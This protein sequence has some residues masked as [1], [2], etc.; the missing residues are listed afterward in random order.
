MN[1]QLA[2]SPIARSTVVSPQ[3]LLNKVHIKVNFTFKGKVL[4]APEKLKCIF[5]SDGEGERKE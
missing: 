1:E 4:I 5:K 3:K 2:V